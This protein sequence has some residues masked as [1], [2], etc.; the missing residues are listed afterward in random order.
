MTDQDKAR[1]RLRLRNNWLSMS[2]A[3]RVAWTEQR[4]HLSDNVL[5]VSSGRTV[6]EVRAFEKR[7]RI[8]RSVAR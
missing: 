6:C 3:A 8:T 7:L 5:A 2:F 1:R 4:R